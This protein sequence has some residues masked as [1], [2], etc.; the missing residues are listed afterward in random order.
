METVQLFSVLV[1]FCFVAAD[2]SYIYQENGHLMSQQPLHHMQYH[3]QYMMPYHVSYRPQVHH[4]HDGGHDIPAAAANVHIPSVATHPLEGRPLIRRQM[5]SFAAGGFLYP[6]YKSVYDA[7]I[8]ELFYPQH[9]PMLD[10]YSD[11]MLSHQG[12]H[13]MAMSPHEN[14]YGMDM[15]L[16][17]LLQANPGN[18]FMAHNSY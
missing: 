4:E 12:D 15:L 10:D 18:M 11:N 1:S 9:Q 8:P 14:S 7:N 16:E 2:Q 13:F 5:A 6:E 17:Q 3:G